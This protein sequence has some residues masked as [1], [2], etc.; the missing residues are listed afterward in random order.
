MESLWETA[1][2]LEHMLLSQKTFRPSRLLLAFPLALFAIDFQIRKMDRIVKLKWWNYNLF[3]CNI[4]L[5]NIGS[6]CLGW[7][8]SLSAGLLKAL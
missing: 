3:E 7:K 6:H 4:D 1:P 5:R 2:S 8:I